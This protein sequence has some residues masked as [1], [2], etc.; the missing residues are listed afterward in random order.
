LT[1]LRTGLVVQAQSSQHYVLDGD[2]I[3]LCRTRGRLRQ[4]R[5]TTTLVATGDQVRYRAT[6]PGAGDIEEVLP[7]RTQLSRRRAGPGRLPI[8]Q[9]IV[10]NPDQVVLIFSVCEP[11][12]NLRMLD[13]LLVI[14]EA[15]ELPTL[16]CA[17]KVDL[18]EGVDEA[19]TLFG[20][21]ERIG[22]RVLYTSA[23]SGEGVAELR[24]RLRGRVSVLCGPSGAGK[25][26]LM[27]II[28]PELD[29]ATQDISLSTGKGRHT[30]VSVRLW[31]LDEGGYV[32]DTPG[33]REAGFYLIDPEELAWYFVEMRPYLSDCRFSSCTHTHEPGCAV[34]AAVETG[35]VSP[36]RHDS[37]CRLRMGE[38]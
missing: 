13:R 17:H 18:A 22:Y 5:S 2:R 3:V 35:A 24:E 25:S 12:P 26:S 16:I 19:R 8:E 36:E 9:V 11:S 34:I 31:P 32:A 20:V 10:A 28:Q 27:N 23:I 37:Y 6:G 29:L 21:Y 7:R 30:T 1:D 33:L 38:G 4:D 15:N 14:C